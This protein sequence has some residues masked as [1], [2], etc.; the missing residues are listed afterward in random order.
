[1]STPPR[2]R[3]P[4]GPLDVPPDVDRRSPVAETQRPQ[5]ADASV[6]SDLPRGEACVSSLTC[7]QVDWSEKRGKG[8]WQ[9]V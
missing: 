3:K 9:G 5:H 6:T 4:A 7:I 8:F 2:G 1:M